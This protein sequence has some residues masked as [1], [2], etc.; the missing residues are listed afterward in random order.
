[1]QPDFVANLAEIYKNLHNGVELGDRT[2]SV[3]CAVTEIGLIGADGYN[4][5]AIV[6]AQPGLR[7]IAVRWVMK[8]LGSRPIFQAVMRPKVVKI[9][10]TVKCS[11]DDLAT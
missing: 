8:V 4:G 3:P 9:M 2:Y 1:V 10:G 5:S 6:V 7:A 11:R